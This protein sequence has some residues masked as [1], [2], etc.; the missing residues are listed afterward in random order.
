[1][2]EEHSAFNKKYVEEVT[3]SKR[4]LLDELNLPP[5]VTEFIRRNEKTIQMVLIAI[6]VLIC[7]NTF[8]DYY[9]QKQKNDSA[10]LLAEAMSQTEDAVRVEQLNKVIDEY[11]GSG[12]ALWSEVSLAQQMLK[13]EK[14]G[15]AVTKYNAII[16][17][18][19]KGSALYPLILQDLARAYDLKGDYQESLKQYSLL[20]EIGGFGTVGYLGEARLYEQM[21]KKEQARDAYEKALAQTDLSPA[22]Q[23]WLEYK[24]DHI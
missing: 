17:D 22:V 7:A 19:G 11:P 6:F 23:E 13:D 2:T 3:P 15:E 21:E 24:L 9:S 8:W 14:Y 20:R 16:S 1:M 5:K 4:T 12:A 10:S 18:V